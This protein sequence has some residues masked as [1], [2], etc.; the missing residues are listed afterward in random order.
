MIDPNLKP[1]TAVN[2]SD[3][4]HRAFE[5]IKQKQFDDAEKFLLG[6]MSKTQDSAAD[7]LY[8][9]VLGVLYKVK[10][11]FKAAWRHYSR[12]EKLLPNDPALKIISARLL[13]EQ[14]A[15]YD[16][17]IKKAKKVLQL[18]PGNPVFAHQ[19]YITMGLAHGMKAE[20]KKAI[21]M[22]EKSWGN[23]FEGFVTAKNI[24]FTLVEM[25]LKKDWGE[26]ACFRF[27]NK[28][29]GFAKN[30]KEEIFADAFQKMLDAFEKERHV[31]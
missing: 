16:S 1:D 14:F 20:Q 25:L 13:I 28:A 22:L 10:G 15:E 11:D 19:A 17:A 2:P 8:H 23:D 5:L 27:M 29:L 4:C 31:D 30:R 26:D 3:V 7:A 9:S 21:A 12:A 6:M 18:L 24:D